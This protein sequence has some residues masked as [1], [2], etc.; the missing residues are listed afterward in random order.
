[1]FTQ[2]DEPFCYLQGLWPQEGW[3][4]VYKSSLRHSS[5]TIFGKDPLLNSCLQCTKNNSLG[6]GWRES[7]FYPRP[8]SL[9]QFSI[10]YTSQTQEPAYCLLPQGL[11]A[12][13][14]PSSGRRFFTCCTW[15]KPSIFPIKPLLKMGQ[16]L[17]LSW[18][19]LKVFSIPKLP[20][21][22]QT[23]SPSLSLASIATL[24]IFFSL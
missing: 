6:Q 23:R 16:V 15:L 14:P 13:V 20:C 12:G 21:V 17:S 9:L 7:S 4:F 2:W 10:T 3:V 8:L 19:L 5:V 11:H 1:M 24:K 22:S 18:D